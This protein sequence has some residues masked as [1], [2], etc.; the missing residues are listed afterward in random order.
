MCLKLN[1][2]IGNLKKTQSNVEM[3]ESFSCILELDLIAVRSN[4]ITT[5]GADILLLRPD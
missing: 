1:C 3:V 4:L 2:Q 5:V